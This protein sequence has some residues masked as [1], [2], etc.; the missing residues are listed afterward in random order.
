M[1]TCGPLSIVTRSAAVAASAWISAS[2][3]VMRASRKSRVDTL[4]SR[5]DLALFQSL[6]MKGCPTF[7]SQ[8]SRSLRTRSAYSGRVIRPVKVRS[9]EP[10]VVRLPET[11]PMSQVSP[12]MS[13]PASSV[14]V[15]EK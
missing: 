11:M 2:E 14:T 10:T 1:R 8:S 13:V 3:A 6:L 15:G 4:S 12:P 9:T 5:V 7:S